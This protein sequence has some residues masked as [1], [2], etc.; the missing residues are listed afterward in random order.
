MRP[1][2]LESLADQEKQETDRNMEEMWRVLAAH[3]DKW[4]LGRQARG[5][6]LRRRRAHASRGAPVAAA[7]GAG[8]PRLACCVAVV[9][10]RQAVLD[11]R[12]V[13]LLDL[14]M[15]CRSFAQTTENLF[16]LSFL[17]RD[18]RVAL[19]VRVARDAPAP[20]GGEGRCCA[21]A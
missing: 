2:E 13:P 12:R 10:V 19:L 7:A 17:V 15:N 11:H 1:E 3:G 20:G 5:A 8:C 14:V 16:T 9:H 18:N 21:P 4:V 6:R